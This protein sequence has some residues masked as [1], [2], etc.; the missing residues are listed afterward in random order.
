MLAWLYLN[1]STITGPYSHFE[2]GVLVYGR[3]LR[4]PMD[5]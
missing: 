3:Q 5:I 2:E 1:G 4:G